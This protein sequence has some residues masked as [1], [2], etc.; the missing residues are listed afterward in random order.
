ML[1][2]IRQVAERMNVSKK[3]IYRRIKDGSLPVVKLS[4]KDFRID[5]ADLAAFVEKLKTA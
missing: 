3:T 5:E 4:E 1:L 2:T